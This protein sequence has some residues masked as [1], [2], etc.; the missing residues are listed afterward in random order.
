M[1]EIRIVRTG[2]PRTVAI[3]SI[4][5]FP[6]VFDHAGQ[7][8][9]MNRQYTKASKILGKRL[10]SIPQGYSLGTGE[11]VQFGEETLVELYEGG[12]VLVIL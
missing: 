4:E 11:V 9:F 2:L 12:A 3:G 6:C 8:Y 10:M 7:L 1:N 5:K